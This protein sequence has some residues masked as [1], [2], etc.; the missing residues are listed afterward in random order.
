MFRF[1]IHE[2]YITADNQKFVS[3]V[4]ADRFGAPAIVK[5]VETYPNAV[6]TDS[7]VKIKELPKVQWSMKERRCGVIARKIGEVPLWKK[8]GTKIITTML[9]VEDNHVIKYYKPNEFEP[10]QKPRVTNLKKFGCL[11]VGAGSTNP[12][13]FTKEYC[14]LFKDSGVM[15]KQ[16]LARFLV[17]PSSQLLPGMN[18]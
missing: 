8:D 2:D 6:S 3:E 16:H 12:S 7:L 10:S 14:G 5:G 13:R 11:L 15:P 9:Q 18:V 1:Q 17:T 4:V